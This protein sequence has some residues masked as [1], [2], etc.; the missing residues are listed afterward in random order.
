MSECHTCLLTA[1]SLGPLI[2]LISTA[3]HQVVGCEKT[4]V[5]QFAEHPQRPQRPPCEQSGRGQSRM[6]DSPRPDD[7]IVLSKWLLD[8]P[9]SSRW[10]TTDDVG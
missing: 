8:L 2:K 6:W 9:M 10:V 3:L 4:Y 5:V 7:G 1:T